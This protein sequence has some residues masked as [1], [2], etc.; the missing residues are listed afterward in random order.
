MAYT[1]EQIKPLI[2][3]ESLNDI[4]LSVTFQVSD[5]DQPI[6]AIEE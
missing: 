2:K 5:K 1:Y 6:Q 4:Q 3:H